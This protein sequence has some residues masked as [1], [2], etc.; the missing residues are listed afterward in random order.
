MV[1]VFLGNFVGMSLIIYL[2][3]LGKKKLNG[4]DNKAKIATNLKLI[5]FDSTIDKKSL[6]NLSLKGLL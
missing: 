5:D 6:T 1:I 3:F 4:F 2:I